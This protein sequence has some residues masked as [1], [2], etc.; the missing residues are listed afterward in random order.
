[1]N[2]KKIIYKVLVLTIWLAVIAGLTTL[3]VAASNRKVAHQCKS[4]EVLIKGSGEKYY[5]EK[6]DIQKQIE[7][8]QG[9]LVGKPLKAIDLGLMERSLERNA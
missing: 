7:S 1:V 5:I 9:K 8:V 2:R 6:G 3:L 4:V